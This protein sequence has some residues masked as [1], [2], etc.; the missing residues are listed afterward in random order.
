MLYGSGCNFFIFAV[1]LCR[2]KGIP[3]AS[4]N[5]SHRWPTHIEYVQLC[6]LLS[7][8]QQRSNIQD[9][10]SI[11]LSLDSNSLLDGTQIAEIDVELICATLLTIYQCELAKGI[12]IFQ[13]ALTSLAMLMMSFKQL[14]A[15]TFVLHAVSPC[16]SCKEY[17]HSCFCNWS[18][19]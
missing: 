11:S 6:Q 3:S 10:L 19:V 14:Y 7:S 17:K 12:T 5:F 16:S 13:S 4:C 9:C 2:S 18:F 15:M 1:G 8:K